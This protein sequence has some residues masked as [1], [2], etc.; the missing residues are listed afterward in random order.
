[1][2]LAMTILSITVVRYCWRAQWQRRRF[3]R[4]TAHAVDE[5]TNDFVVVV[6]G[7]GLN[8]IEMTLM[9]VTTT[10]GLGCDGYC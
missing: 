4:P 5:F 1:M 10:M 9:V 8:A 3:S 2:T 7:A 6:V